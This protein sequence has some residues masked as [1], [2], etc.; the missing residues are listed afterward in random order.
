MDEYTGLGKRDLNAE[1]H[2]QNIETTGVLKN[3]RRKLVIFPGD[4][5]DT[6]RAANGFAKIIDSVFPENE[7]P[8]IYSLVY[9]DSSPCYAHRLY[10]Q[11]ATNHLNDARY[12]LGRAPKPYLDTF[13]QE[14]ILPLISQKNGKE[15][16]PLEEAAQYLRATTIG[17]H[18]HG[19]TVLLDI[20]NKLKQSM[21]ELGYSSQEQAF[22]LKQIVSINFCSSM[23]LEQTQTSALHIISQADGQAVANWRFGSLN[24]Y[25]Q[26]NKLSQNET[27]LF[28]TSDNEKCLVLRNIYDLGVDEIDGASPDEHL[29][30]IYL[31]TDINSQ[32]CTPES[33]QA[34]QLIHQTMRGVISA[35]VSENMWQYMP[36]TDNRKVYENSG[37]KYY[38]K[39]QKRRQLINQAEE[40]L[41]QVLNSGHQLDLTKLPMAPLFLRRN[42]QGKTPF[43]QLI[44]N[45][46]VE[47]I[48]QI[49]KSIKAYE[50]KEH[51][52][53]L[54]SRLINN[55]IEYAAQNKRFDIAQCFV[56]KG[57]TSL[58]L[59]LHADK[60]TADD[61]PAMLPILEKLQTG[62]QITYTLLPIYAKSFQISNLLQRRQT[63]KRLKKLVF[64]DKTSVHENA[65]LYNFC[66]K[67]ENPTKQ[68]MQTEF[69]NKISEKL[70]KAKN[71]KDVHDIVD[72]ERAR[73]ASDTSHNL[74]EGLSTE[75]KIRLEQLSHKIIK[76]KLN[77]CARE[78]VIRGHKADFPIT[79]FYCRNQT[80]E[81]KQAFD[82][83]ITKLNQAYLDNPSQRTQLIEQMKDEMIKRN[84]SIFKEEL[85]KQNQ[86]LTKDVNIH[87]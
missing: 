54:P 74:Y 46:N 21:Q 24:H 6:D 41:W 85:K 79:L 43:E 7:K 13:Y 20:E 22:L 38:Q 18:C 81:Q 52:A 58:P 67:F 47:E 9:R 4:G 2:W 25:I 39:F 28:N 14:Q 55:T 5:T 17:T 31:Q 77:E 73:Q 50:T 86:P 30:R 69:T 83:L 75:A 10:T 63:Q 37:K 53:L 59:Q 15:R 36:Q 34:L 66:E 62:G 64:L 19:S 48:K 70:A 68:E 12:P 42:N 11:A 27:A 32:Y 49:Y 40:K 82:E 76:Q 71:V 78:A 57:A 65:M 29:G 26:K 72:L 87:D 35:P 44:Q 8:E 56:G 84:P 45:G 51:D 16:L 33:T 80:P 60:I 61:I 23:P 3:H 1:H